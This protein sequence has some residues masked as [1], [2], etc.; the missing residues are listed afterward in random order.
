M[1]FSGALV[2]AP[3]TQSV[4][5]L[6][7]YLGPSQVCIKPVEAPQ[8]SEAPS[9]EVRRP[10]TQTEIAIDQGTYYESGGQ[11]ARTQLETAQI[12]LNDCLAC[13]GCVTSAE[14][15]LIGMQSID[16]VK[17]ELAAPQGRT[18]VASIS[19][20]SLA[21]LVVRYAHAHPSSS[22]EAPLTQAAL[23]RRITAAL[24]QRGFHIVHDTSFARHLALREHQREFRERRKA[25]QDGTKDAPRLPML[26][27]ACPGWICY[28][29]KAHSE[30][31]PYI[32]ATKSPQQVSGVL[33]KRWLGPA[34]REAPVY[35]VAVMPCYDKKLEASRAQFEQDG[36]KEVDCV[37]TT[38]ELH[39]LLL[40]TNFD[41]Y[42]PVPGEADTPAWPELLQEPGSSSGG[43][44]FAILHTVW[45]EW[46]AA[47]PGAAPTL[48]LR[49]IRSVDYTDYVLRSP[50]GETV[51]KG[52]Q[53]YGFRNL[54]NLVRKIQ[55]ETGARSARRAARG[56][57]V[58]RGA[59]DDA[60]YD[61]VEVMACP[62]GCVNGGGQMRPP[63]D[64][65]APAMPTEDHAQ[66]W[67]GTDKKWVQ[68]VEDA[69]WI[70]TGRRAAPDALAAPDA[71]AAGPLRV[72]HAA[73]S[74]E[75]HAWLAHV[76]ASA[77]EVEAR[78]ALRETH[79]LRTTYQGVAPQTNGLAVQW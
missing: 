69:Y 4:T 7:D 8:A 14:T 18:F 49:V 43:Y 15:V 59:E 17:R 34:L 32:A 64:A 39:D 70:D 40:E 37:L 46:V 44:L 55:R 24:Q 16:E 61:Y 27:S 73:A 53:C 2:R 11:R 77:A 21:S 45:D 60:P 38:G 3:L 23:L 66:G 1:A 62:G 26:A 12:S 51:F 74:G 63:A 71:Q 76:D 6:N 5:D 52:A 57:M 42:A 29:E 22:K 79:A 47:H 25:R 36:V 41:P 58:R 48:E 13:S 31:L 65:V 54:Q 19:P 75:L 20:Q 78:L 10:L 56:R 35:H 33:A 68:R 67:Q 50:E 28:A 30:L 9:G 72:L